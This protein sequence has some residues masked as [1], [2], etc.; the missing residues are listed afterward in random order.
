MRFATSSFCHTYNR[1]DFF[2]IYLP[3]LLFLLC[4]LEKTRAVLY[5]I[6]TSTKLFS[7]QFRPV[8]QDS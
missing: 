2:Y 8:N 7:E 6:C 4:S 3:S 5:N 1:K